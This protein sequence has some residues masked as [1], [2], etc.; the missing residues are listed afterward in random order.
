MTEVSGDDLKEGME[1]VIG[2]GRS[3]DLAEDGDATTNPF[4][5]KIRPGGTPP[6]PKQ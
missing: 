3:T 2:E 6:K 1:V 4:L 5:P